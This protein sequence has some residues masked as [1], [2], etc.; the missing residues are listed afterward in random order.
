MTQSD[1]EPLAGQRYRVQQG[2]TQGGHVG[3]CHRVDQYPVYRV[4]G[5]VYIEPG[6]RQGQ[7]NGSPN[8][9]NISLSPIS[10]VFHE[11]AAFDEKY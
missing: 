9:N 6:L 1:E 8:I 4:P 3:S 5:P 2:C 10:A 7:Y 11:I